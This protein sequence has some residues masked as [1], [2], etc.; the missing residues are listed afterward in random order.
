MMCLNQYLINI[1]SQKVF[2]L[3][4]IVINTGKSDAIPPKGFYLPKKIA[5]SRNAY[6]GR[7]TL[8]GK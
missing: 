4:S 6:F 8:Y 2:F 1:I 3:D 7:K 5:T